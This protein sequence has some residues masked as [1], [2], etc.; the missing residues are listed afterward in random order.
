MFSVHL[1]SINISS[2]LRNSGDFNN[3]YADTSKT[4]VLDNSSNVEGFD[5]TS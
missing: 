2:L 1:L 4:S 3:T 5:L